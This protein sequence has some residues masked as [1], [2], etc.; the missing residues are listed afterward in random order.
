MNKPLL[1]P[2]LTDVETV[3]KRLEADIKAAEEYSDLAKATLALITIFNRKRGGEVQRMK[4]SDVEIKPKMTRVDKEILEGLSETEKRLTQVLERIEIRGKFG[5]PVPI[6][7]TP[8]MAESLT[9][10]KKLRNSESRYFFI[11]PTGE[12]PYRGSDVLRQY[13]KA[14]GVSENAIFTATNLRKQLATLS[15][16]MAVSDLDQDQLASF[17]G[18]DIRIYRNTYRRPLEVVQKARV[19]SILFKMNRGVPVE[20]E[21][22]LE[23][24]EVIPEE[25]ISCPPEEKNE[26]EEN[27]VFQEEDHFV[28]THPMDTS[29]GMEVAEVSHVTMPMP[30]KK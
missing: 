30:K 14:C 3:C 25:D 21:E 28:L 23:A 10:L 8:V 19:A 22:N 20:G 7:L 18:H 11:T 24:E 9:R 4:L 13:S 2:T 16:S 12:N 5:R 27:E 29:E 26:E 6:L 15:Q 17:L 1:L